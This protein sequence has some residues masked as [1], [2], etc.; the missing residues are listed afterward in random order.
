MRNNLKNLLKVCDYC[1]FPIFASF[2]WPQICF[3]IAIDSDSLKTKRAPGLFPWGPSLGRWNLGGTDSCGP[4]EE[5][6]KA[7]A[8]LQTPGKKGLQRCH[9]IP[10]N[11]LSSPLNQRFWLN[12]KVGLML[13]LSCTKKLSSI[14]QWV[15][16]FIIQVSSQLI[17]EDA[18]DVLLHEHS[19]RR[20]KYIVIQYFPW[21]I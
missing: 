17:P 15:K 7:G 21:M 19:P 6:R 4:S 8:I 18:Y 13:A 3:P 20:L 1:Y 2:F 14:P 12:Y 10:R 16:L 9:W 5:E 11:A